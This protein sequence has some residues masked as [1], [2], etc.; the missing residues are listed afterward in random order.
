MA[1]LPPERHPV[2]IVDPN[3]V[4]SG[5][6][7][8]QAFQPISGWNDEILQVGSCVDELELPLRASP[9]LAWNTPGCPRVAF[10]EQV[11]RCF[12]RE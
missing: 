4:P 5:L 2:L 6:V 9:E 3:T 12:V 8:L 7:S 11:C 1:V 10:S